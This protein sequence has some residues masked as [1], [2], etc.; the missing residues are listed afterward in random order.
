VKDQQLASNIA[1]ELR[2]AQGYHTDSL[3]KLRRD[4]LTA[5]YM[6]TPEG[7]ENAGRHGVSSGDVADM[8]ESITA[9]ML[10]ALKGDSIVEFEA[11]GDDDVEQAQTETDVV[12]SIIIERNMGYTLFQSAIRDALLLRNGW[13]KSCLL[14]TSPS[15]RD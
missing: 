1:T 8:V 5:Y 4:A 13:I 2:D 10:P 9:Q 15:P 12:N 14:Y 7:K 11:E 3:S 6:E